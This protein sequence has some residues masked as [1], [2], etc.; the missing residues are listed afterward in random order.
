MNL[1]TWTFVFAIMDHGTLVATGGREFFYQPQCEAAIA[2]MPYALPNGDII[3]ARCL[4][5]I[6]YSK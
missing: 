4:R 2:A 3:K 5:T 1:I 6:T